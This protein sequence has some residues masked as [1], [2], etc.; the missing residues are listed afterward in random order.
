MSG[1]AREFRI[2]LVE[3][4]PKG[5]MWPCGQNACW[6]K[7]VHL[8]TKQAVTVYSGEYGQHKARSLAMEALELILACGAREVPQFIDMADELESKA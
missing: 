6:V 1:K 5:G 8:P 2:D 4:R 3:D 7:A